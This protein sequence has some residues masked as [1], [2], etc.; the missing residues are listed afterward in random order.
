MNWIF[1]NWLVIL[2]GVGFI[3]FHL[4]GHS[5]HGGHRGGHKHS[6]DTKPI[7]PPLDA[8]PDPLSSVPPVPD[9]VAVAEEEPAKRPSKPADQQR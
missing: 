7:P 6:S 1:D 3:A 8:T 9:P 2:L 4:F 5:G